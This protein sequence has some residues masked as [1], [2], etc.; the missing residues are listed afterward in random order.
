MQ[1]FSYM[2]IYS[3]FASQSFWSK[4]GRGPPGNKVVPLKCQSPKA[5]TEQMGFKAMVPEKRSLDP[6]GSRPST[7]SETNVMKQQMASGKVLVFFLRGGGG[8]MHRSGAPR[9]NQA[10]P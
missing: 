1:S 5:E 9:K 10:V 8:G 6:S 7:T 2:Y 3:G 4:L